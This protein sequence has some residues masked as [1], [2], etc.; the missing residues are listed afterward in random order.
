MIKNVTDIMKILSILIRLYFA[1]GG[2]MALVAVVN[3]FMKSTVWS[4]W[5]LVSI[6]VSLFLAVNL[7]WFAVKLNQLL[8]KRK[9][10]VQGVIFILLLN[11]ILTAFNG[12]VGLNHAKEFSAV[13]LQGLLI[14]SL[15]AATFYGLLIFVVEKLSSSK[16]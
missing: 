13:N 2:V 4:V 7:L 15:V 3:V 16:L 5:V 10:Y 6:V 11:Q 14:L 9:H 12:S 1:F 8:P